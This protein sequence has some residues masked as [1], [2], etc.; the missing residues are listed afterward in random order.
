MRLFNFGKKKEQNQ[1]GE[2]F[3]AKMALQ[4][5]LEE[6]KETREKNE[7]YERSFKLLNEENQ[8]LHNNILVLQNTI[9]NIKNL[10]ED[11][12]GKVISANTILK[13]LGE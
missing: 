12:K 3:I 7:S 10:C 9:E 4:K 1:K 11:R 6:L 2:D 8:D 5:A 13:E